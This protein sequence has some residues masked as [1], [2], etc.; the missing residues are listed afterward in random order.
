[1]MPHTVPNSPTKGD[2]V[3]TTASRLRSRS[4]R[5]PS[6]VMTWFSSRSTW[7]IKRSAWVELIVLPFWS[8]QVPVTT[9]SSFWN[10][11][12]GWVPTWAAT[13]SSARPELR[14]FSKLSAC[15]L[16]RPSAKNFWM[17]SAHD[18]KE[19]RIKRPM[20]HFTTMSACRNNWMKFSGLATVPVA[21]AAE[22]AS[23]SNPHLG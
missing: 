7:A 20:M 2:A 22:L 23:I 8:R 17:I 19:A 11:S 16:T 3:A 1:M 21:P 15:L 10:A 9:T 6:E 18:T 4:T 5:S 12:L 13:S 14:I